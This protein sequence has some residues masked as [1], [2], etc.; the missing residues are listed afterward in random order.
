MDEIMLGVL[1]TDSE[2]QIQ[3]KRMALQ[4]TIYRFQEQMLYEMRIQRHKD[5]CF[6]FLFDK[7]KDRDCVMLYVCFFL[8]QEF[9]L[10]T[11]DK[12]SKYEGMRFS[13]FGQLSY[14]VDNVVVV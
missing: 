10:F 13:M 9:R 14:S 12:I 11:I 4:T 8:Q 7:Y 1:I 6:F 2:M 3:L 5:K